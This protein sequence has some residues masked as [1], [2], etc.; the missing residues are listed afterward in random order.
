MDESA[1]VSTLT[2]LEK[3]W[4]GLDWWLNFW[5]AVV[6][7]GVAVELIV[8]IAEYTHDWR[9]FRRGIIHSPEK[10]SMVIFGLGFLGAALVAIGVAGEF[11]IHT[12][13]GKIE[14]DMRDKTGQLV[15]IVDARAQTAES[16]NE[17]LQQ[18]LQN[19]EEKARGRA[20][21][22]A[23]EAE[24][25][26]LARV[27]IEESLQPR[28]ITIEDK[29]VLGSK[30]LEFSG[31]IVSLWFPAGD[32]EAQVLSSELATVLYGLHWKV[33]APAAFMDWA[34]SGRMFTG[35]DEVKT[36][37][38]I[39]NTEDASAGSAAHSLADTLNRLGFDAN[40]SPRT[41]SL[42]K[43]GASLVIVNVWTRPLGP[44]GEPKLR[45]EKVKK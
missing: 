3:S 23:K 25:E 18:R 40:R 31:Q 17:T 20:N 28:R 6:V 1:L 13:A 35:P 43:Y 33:F 24:D 9:D 10:P 22:L 8:L 26:R 5:T 38:E 45:A 2:T 15:A 14:A 44:Q 32:N 30:L 39:A 37:I 29:R 36:G 4:S 11:R 21:E 27:Q 41:E 16:D 12:K 42:S 7:I 19:Q 34:E